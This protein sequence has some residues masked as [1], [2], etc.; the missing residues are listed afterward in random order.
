[1]RRYGYSTADA[2]TI[3]GNGFQILVMGT[4]LTSPMLD[5]IGPRW[6]AAIGLGS[7]CVGLGVLAH[8][9]SYD[10]AVLIL[11]FAYGLVGLGGN[12]L[13]LSSMPF[14]QLFRRSSTAASIMMGAYQA[15]GFVFM[16]L[17]LEAFDFWTFFS[18]YQLIAGVGLL[19]SFFAFPDTP[20]SCPEDTPRCSLPVPPC[21]R[22]ACGR[23]ESA[24]LQHAFAPLLLSRT[25]YFL[26]CFSLSA[27]V[28]AWC[29][30]TFYAQLKGKDHEAVDPTMSQSLIFWMPLASNSTF[31]FTPL[32]GALIDARGFRPAIFLLCLATVGCVASVWLLPLTWQW[33]TLLSLNWLLAV[34]YSLQLSYI[35]CKYAADQFGAVMSFSTVMQSVIN[36]IGV[37]LLNC[38]PSRAA[39]CFVPACV[40]FCALWARDERRGGV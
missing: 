31:L 27:T 23:P 12:M 16:L 9:A 21:G 26:L 29:G 38:P 33:L 2:T 24:A 1:M 6:F 13:M 39:A 36:L 10:H 22:G 28:A 15:A 18:T 14:C 37:Y 34:T 4:A 7:E 30:G 17:T 35:T 40:F 19:A 11:S 25:W 32:I 5:V 8:T 3:W 20:F